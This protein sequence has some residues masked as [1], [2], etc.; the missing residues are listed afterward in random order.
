MGGD[1]EEQPQREGGGGERRE[2]EGEEVVFRVTRHTPRHLRGGQRR[3]HTSP[4]LTSQHSAGKRM[5]LDD[6]SPAPPR[7]SRTGQ[8][9]NI[10][11]YSIPLYT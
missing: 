10:P 2:G 8:C 9:N 1:E 3:V 6:T 5:R 7:T 4:H 11:I